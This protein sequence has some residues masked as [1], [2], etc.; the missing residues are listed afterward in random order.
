MDNIILFGTE[1]NPLEAFASAMGIVAVYFQVKQKLAFWPLW[2]FTALIYI[3]I[4]FVSKLYA[5]MSL[6]FYYVGI[7]IYGWY[8]WIKG[9][10]EDDGKINLLTFRQWMLTLA[11]AATLT[12]AFYFFLKNFT[13]SS[14]PF[15][16]GFAT[17]LCF[18]ASWLLSHKFLQ[19]WLM[20]IVADIVS[21]GVYFSQKLYPTTI[22]F[23]VLTFMA[24]IGYFQWKK[25]IT[26]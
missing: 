16:D 8:Q 2:I 26:E 22:F 1:I 19:H 7:S 12:V 23:L 20:W 21:T 25:Q 15:W 3:Y 4:F 11:A 14:V 18:V 5:L 6:Q 24:I 13:D 10:Q 17:A 9:N